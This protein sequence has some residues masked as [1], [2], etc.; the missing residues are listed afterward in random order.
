M[1]HIR[2]LIYLLIFCSCENNNVCEEVM[3]YYQDGN[4]K[5][6]HQYPN[7][8]RKQNFTRIHFYPNGQKSS[9][10]KYENGLKNGEFKTWYENGQLSAIWETEN[11]ISK[12][13][14]ICYRQDGTIE[15]EALIQGEGYEGYFRFYDEDE[16]LL[17]EGSALNDSIRIGKWVEYY[18]N[19]NPEYIWQYELGMRDGICS[20]YYESGVLESILIFKRDSL[21]DTVVIY[22]LEENILF[23]HNRKK[24]N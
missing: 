23:N 14:V 24:E 8:N 10:G 12:G 22:D 17:S 5:L 7:C 20:T 3:E 4:V 1:N 2:I 15:R 21:K 11:G 6:I 19:G 16:N 13:M 9:Y 18:K